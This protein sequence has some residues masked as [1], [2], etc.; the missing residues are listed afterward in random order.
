M[1]AI[2][3]LAS[4]SDWVTVRSHVFTIYGTLRGDMDEML[5][6]TMTDAELA[7]DVDS[8]ALRFQETVDRLPM[9]LGADSPARIGDRVLAKYHDVRND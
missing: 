9:L 5:R 2:A 4:L 6:E 8:R 3:V 1:R 7:K